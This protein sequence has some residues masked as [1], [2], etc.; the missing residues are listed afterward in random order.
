M[1]C[2][3]C[4]ARN[5]IGNKFCRECGQKMPLE[6]NLLAA[7]EAQQVE[8]ERN[9]ERAAKLLTEAFALSQQGKPAEALPRAEE[10]AALLPESTSA[11]TLSATLYERLG[12]NDRAIAAMEKVVAL[13]PDSAVDADKLDRLRRGVHL[14]PKRPT[15]TQPEPE[16]ERRWVPIFIGVG[17]GLIALS[18]GIGVL[19]RL[20]QKPATPP[21]RLTLAPTPAPALPTPTTGMTMTPGGTLGPLSPPSMVGRPDPFKP[22]GPVPLSG[23]PTP[24]PS[25]VEPRVGRPTG[26]LLPNPQEVPTPGPESQGVPP[27]TFPAGPNGR[28]LPPLGGVQR[29]TAPIQAGPPTT[30][31]GTSIPAGPPSNSEAPPPTEPPSSQEAPGIIR[32]REHSGRERAVADPVTDPL[33]KAQTLQTAG[34][35][36]E[37]I[38]AYREALAQ[39]APVGEVQQGIALSYQ[40][41]GE[42]AAARAAYQHAIVA[43]EAQVQAGRR[44]EQASR[45]IAA[46]RAALDVLGH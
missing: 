13:N 30:G 31:G 22:N 43:F 10:A 23:L 12:Q 16:A 18:V 45:G 39:G 19:V 25:T 34:K 20:N 15:V 36:R 6:E 2:P 21:A 1:N 46:C 41:L 32:I 42:K 26:A 17:A 11:L 3:N 9:R 44:V 35:Y 29:N 40:R 7:E 4:K 27:L 14:M 37:A 33:L 28:G 8:A 24:A 38:T 5:P